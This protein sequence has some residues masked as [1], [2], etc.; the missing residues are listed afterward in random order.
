[1]F[2]L[3]ADNLLKV[4]RPMVCVC[5]CFKLY[6]DSFRTLINCEHTGIC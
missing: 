5:L 2:R 4:E 3:L 1:M 6:T